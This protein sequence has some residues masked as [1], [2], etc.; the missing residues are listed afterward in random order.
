M[1]ERQGVRHF[2]LDIVKAN[3]KFD[4]IDFVKCYRQAKKYAIKKGKNLSIV[5]GTG[6]YLKALTT[7]ISQLPKIDKKTKIQIAKSIQNIQKCYEFLQTTDPQY[8]DKI[9]IKDDY[10]IEKAITIYHL[11]GQ[12]PS[13]YFENNPQ[14]PV[15]KDIK[16]FNLTINKTQLH[17]NIEKRTTNMLQYGL[18][19][20]V[21]ALENRFHR[22]CQSMGSIGIKECLSYLDGDINI[23]ELKALIIQNTKNLAKQQ[24]TFN[25]SQFINT[26]CGDRVKLTK[27]LNQTYFQT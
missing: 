5:G 23:V 12:T 19:D 21:I 17:K 24:K 8:M 25:N 18:I 22:G 1:L 4:V 27:I 7:G 15:S 3:Q 6:F 13:E 10:R 11:S 20:E 26:V 2:G 9:S 16:I 14:A